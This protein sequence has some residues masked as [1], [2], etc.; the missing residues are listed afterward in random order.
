MKYVDMRIQQALNKEHL[1]QRRNTRRIARRQLRPSTLPSNS[2]WYGTRGNPSAR[3]MIVGES[4]GI[5][6][7]RLKLPF[8]GKSGDLLE[9]LLDETDINIADCFFCNI[10]SERPMNND[11]SYFFHK[12]VDAKKLNA[13]NVRG[14]YP[15][16]NVINGCEILRQLI[17]KINP[18]LIIGL[19]N[20]T[21]W[22]LTDDCYN[23]AR[24]TTT[25]RVTPSGISS[26]RGSQLYTSGA[27][28]GRKIPF[29]P[30]Y[31]PAATF[32]TY[33][34]RG[35]IKHDLQVR[36]PHA[37]INQWDPPSWDFTIRPSFAV[38]MSTL[39]DLTPA[40]QALSRKLA[41]DL[42][43]RNEQIA[44]IGIAWSNTDAICIPLRTVD[45]EKDYSYWS[46][47]EELQIVCEL[48]KL[49][50]HPE[51]EVVGQNFL[52][53]TQYLAA[54]IFATPRIA[55]DTMLKHHTVFP[56]GGDPIKKTGPQ[57]LVQKSLHHLSSLYCQY[58][59]YW[60]D[61]GKDWEETMDEERL[62]NYNCRDSVATFEVDAVLDSLVDEYKLNEQYSFQM[63]QANELALPMM[64]D[65]VKID[66]K[67]RAQMTLDLQDAIARFEQKID[68][69]V[70][71]SVLPRSKKKKAW[72]NSPQQLAQLFYDE[73]GIKEVIHP[74][75]KRRTTNKSA[76]P[77]IAKRE[78]LVAPI[79][80]AIEKL[81]SIHVYY[82]T[83]LT[84]GLDSDE[85]MRCSYNVA[86]TDTFRW[87]SS[88]NVFGRG[89]NLQN[90]PEGD[91]DEE[92]AT[93]QGVRFPNVKKLFIPDLGKLIVDGDLAGADAAVVAWE[94]NDESLKE[95]I[96]SGVKL[97]S[98]VAKELYGTDGYPH[99]DMC[100]RRIHATNYGV[101]VKTLTE[102]LRGLYGP[103][104]T[105][106][107]IE[108]TFQQY[109]F[110]NHPGIKHWHERVGESLRETQGVQN[111][112]GNRIIYV[113][114]LDQ[115]FPK[116][117]AWVPQSTIAL[118]CFRGML[119]LKK[120]FPFITILLQVHDS[121]V[122]QF[123]SKYR[124]QLRDMRDVLNKVTIPYE[125][126]L[127]IPWMLKVSNKSWGDCKTVTFGGE[128]K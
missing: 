42:E 109:W 111:A 46:A 75:T 84:M 113:D 69:M 2:I 122:F 57:G 45:K 65:G 124:G 14:L 63:Q 34:W 125:D 115:V 53:D 96:R 120:E 114:R 64:L 4:W 20:Y 70:P 52:Y 6:E 5:E 21:L 8:V 90:I 93:T 29:L 39:R 62:W 37:L 88:E 30:T 43:T 101:S 50:T 24:D 47:Y 74:V 89:G 97:H 112:F 119:A 60:K 31:H 11:M 26:W 104:Y 51:I 107:D 123:D 32:R 86:G 12:N 35:M 3:I 106:R 9:D 55:D 67:L 68:P 117:L 17:Q 87:S 13:I 58:H 48:R 103:E 80:D 61:E 71:E 41:V 56:G 66:T 121:A 79:I 128:K 7:H 118:I 15:H 81:R 110:D 16:D 59:S 91:T 105:S 95:A 19:G 36:V 73:L 100:K 126:P 83:F 33:A 98:V 10:V 40:A 102:T 127:R 23:Y 72:Y 25:G 78:P 44:C 85:R 1:N 27:I 28:I 116:A 82:S 94:S 49:L 18:K 38:V 54:C 76:L 108:A 92:A 77:L 22:A 99:Y